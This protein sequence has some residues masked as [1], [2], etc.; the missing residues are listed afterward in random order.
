MTRSARDLESRDNHLKSNREVESRDNEG[1]TTYNMDFATG[2][3]IP[4]GAKKEGYDYYWAATNIKGE[5]TRDVEKLLARGWELVPADR[6][7]YFSKD[8]LGRNPYHGKYI[9]TFDLILMERPQIYLQRERHAYYQMT[10]NKIR[11]LQ[12]NRCTIT[13]GYGNLSTSGSFTSHANMTN[14]NGFGIS[15]HNAFGANRIDSF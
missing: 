13:D 3:T 2:L 15:N 6:A 12:T 14:Y 11:A 9:A 5:P 7:P 8:P 4:H 1:L 10:N